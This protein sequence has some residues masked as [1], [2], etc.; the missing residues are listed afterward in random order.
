MVSF[1]P[2]FLHPILQLKVFWVHPD[3]IVGDAIIKIVITPERGLGY[4][5]HS[6]VDSVADRRSCYSDTALKSGIELLFKL[7]VFFI[8]PPETVQDCCDCSCRS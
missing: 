8:S 1:S 4:A 2:R 3:I 6:T 7:I 5:A